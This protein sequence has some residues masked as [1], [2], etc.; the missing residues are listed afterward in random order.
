MRSMLL[1]VSSVLLLAVCL[2]GRAAGQAGPRISPHLALARICVSEA[3]WTCFET[4]D[5]VAIHE[6]LLRGALRHGMRY[7]TFAATYSP[8]ATGVEASRLRPWIGSLREDGDTPYSWPRIISRTRR[9]GTVAVEP[10]PPWSHYRDRWL[11]VLE[12]AREVVRLSLGDVDEWGVCAQPVHD[13]GGAMDRD[14]A[15]RIGLIEI[16]CGD[17][18]NDFYARPSLARADDA[19]RVDLD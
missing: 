12:R 4:G 9:D 10:H 7:G 14:R 15:R 5:G 18:S 8:R 13:W 6:V 3:G 1:T 19:E 2:F 11:A 17:T 16:E